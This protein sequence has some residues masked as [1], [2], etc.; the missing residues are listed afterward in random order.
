MGGGQKENW[1]D[2]SEMP[3]AAEGSSDANMPAGG[4]TPPSGTDGNQMMPSGDGTDST[5]DDNGSQM[6][7][8]PSGMDGNQ[9]MPS[10]DGTDS[11]ADDSGSQ[12]M[13][14]PSGTDGNQ[15]MP[16]GDGTDSTADNSEAAAV[17]SLGEGRSGWMETTTVYLPVGVPVYSGSKTATFSI[18]Q[19]GDELEVQF[20]TDEN[21]TEVITK[22]WITGTT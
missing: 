21:G 13:T 6:M 15:M 10:G 1:G 4:M 19:A 16:S 3:T 7:T 22:I 2:S 18:L 20:E 14:P 12:M 17:A 11:T 9:M 8:P 5:V